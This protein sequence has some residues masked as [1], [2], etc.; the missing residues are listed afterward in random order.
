MHAL[1]CPGFK[2]RMVDDAMSMTVIRQYRA[3]ATAGEC[4]PWICELHLALGA[5]RGWLRWQRRDEDCA[6]RTREQAE[7]RIADLRRAG[8]EGD[9]RTIWK[10]AES[11]MA[12]FTGA[13][14]WHPQRACEQAEIR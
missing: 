1:P 10:A 14:P 3:E 12:L 9:D 8:W 7:A 11:T 13:M 5:A 6:G 2:Y 4:P